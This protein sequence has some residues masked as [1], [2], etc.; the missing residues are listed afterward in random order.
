MLI[1]SLNLQNVVS[2]NILRMRYISRSIMEAMILVF[3][4]V[5]PRRWLSVFQRNILLIYYPDSYSPSNLIVKQG[6]FCMLVILLFDK[7]AL[8]SV[9]YY[10]Q[11]TILKCFNFAI[12]TQ[13]HVQTSKQTDL[14][15]LFIVVTELG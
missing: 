2:L 9:A 12:L 3:W 14:R 10:D 5:I 6:I 11:C 15:F 1:C 8:Y 13:F 7:T 4:V